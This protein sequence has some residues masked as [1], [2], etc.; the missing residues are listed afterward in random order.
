EIPF[1][2]HI[3]EVSVW[4]GTGTGTQAYT[5]GSSVQLTRLRPNGGATASVLSG[6]LASPGSSTN[7]NKVC[8]VA[9]LGGTCGNG[10]PSSS[11]V[12]LTGG[13]PV[14]LNGGDVVYVSSATGD[15]VQTWS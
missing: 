14:A 2:A 13:A 11:S 6:A 8:A 12:S 3:V 9:S 15:A 1:A 7:S 5:G 4:G 10:L